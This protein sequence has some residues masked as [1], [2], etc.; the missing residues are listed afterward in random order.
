VTGE[1]PTASGNAACGCP[2]GCA[3]ICG[4]L[5]D[6]RTN[7]LV[8]SALIPVSLERRV[9]ARGSQLFNQVSVVRLGR[10]SAS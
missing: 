7:P 5:L 9:G 6:P 4:R 10:Y 3:P 8:V 2:C 1:S